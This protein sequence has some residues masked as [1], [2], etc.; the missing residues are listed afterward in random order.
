MTRASV[1]ERSYATI[2]DDDLRCLA[3]IAREDLA[4]FAARHNRPHLL[5]NLLCIALCQG[6]ALHYL[7]Q[8]NGVKDFDVYLFFA[9]GRE[10]DFNAR[11]RTKYDYGLSRFG[12]H[13]K[14]LGYKGRRVDVIGRSIP[15]RSDETAVQS[16]QR[17]LDVKR[18][19]TAWHLARKAVVVLEPARLRG[20]VIHPAS[21][22]V[23]PSWSR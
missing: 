2:N 3:G 7:N 18:S 15:H 11:R 5:D 12:R 20:R 22:R 10:R 19:K 13:P 23:A 8:T 9:K 17:Y 4:D 16:V 14:D 21:G 6:A 1:S